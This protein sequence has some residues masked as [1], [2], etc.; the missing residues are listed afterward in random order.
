MNNFINNVTKK[1]IWGILFL[2]ILIINFIYIKPFGDDLVFGSNAL[3]PENMTFIEATIT[4]YM[5]WTPR[6]IADWLAYFF[7]H[8]YTMF[9]IMNSIVCAIFIYLIYMLTNCIKENISLNNK[10]ICIFFVCMYPWKDMG[11]AG[12]AVTFINYLWPFTALLYV[13]YILIKYNNKKNILLVEYMLFSIAMIFACNIELTLIYIVCYSFIIVIY[14]I[15]KKNRNMLNIFTLLISILGL[16]FIWLSPGV[17]NR[18]VLSIELYYPSYQMLSFLDKINLGVIT[19]VFHFIKNSEA[20][21]LYFFFLLGLVIIIYKKYPNKYYYILLIFNF[22]WIIIGL[23]SNVAQPNP[24]LTS[25]SAY[26]PTAISIL[27]LLWP[28]L[29]LYLIYNDT[30][31]KCFIIITIYLLS[32]MDR[33]IMG[34]SPSIF[35]SSTR[36]YLPVFIMLILI[37]SIIY[38]NIFEYPNERLNKK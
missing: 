13:S 19:T 7:A 35:E 28:C 38:I 37:N 3:W 6:I 36:T 32:F 9:K 30:I 33:F 10:L 12:Y 26:I 2:I 17:E 25:I 16:L 5:E 22:I 27:L 23:Y 24:I 8:H 29:G 15:K 21:I 18:Y 31:I 11:T 4:R 20:L 14:N 34:F 1:N